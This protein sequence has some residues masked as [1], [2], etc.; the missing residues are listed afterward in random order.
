MAAEGYWAGMST[1]LRPPVAHA[2]VEQ[3]AKL[4]PLDEPAKV[5]GKSVRDAIPK[6]PVKDAVSG[7]WLGH[8]LHPLLTDLP[9]GTWTSAVLLDWLGG[10][11]GADRA[12]DR[13]IGLGLAASVPAAL[14]GLNDWA[15]SEPASASVRRVGLVHAATNV[16]ATALF[17]AS[18]AARRGGSRGSGKLL[19][20]LGAGALGV[21]GH[22]GGHLSYAEGV[23]VDQTA[24]ED[25]PEDWTPVM[26]E[27][28][29]AE[30]EPRYA[31][32]H[33]VGVLVVR[34]GDGVHALS[35]RCCHRGGALDEGELDDGCVVCPLHGSVFRLSDGAVMRG[36][37]AYPQPVWQARV[38]AGVIELKAP[39]EP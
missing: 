6:G 1:S 29:L 36:P 10:G 27:S 38:R 11:R 24:F 14:T 13:L 5:I 22:L 21:S 28:E 32:A 19:A 30:G 33:G 25:P 17:G 35:N 16:A 12:A 26:R 15:D 37:A 4:E 31:E 9:I 20:L 34:D 18:L 39:E 23:G 8:A 7:T 3:L 2:A